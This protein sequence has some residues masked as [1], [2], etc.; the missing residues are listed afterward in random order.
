MNLS[1]RFITATFSLAFLAPFVGMT[2]AQGAELGSSDV[3]SNTFTEISYH[4]DYDDDYDYDYDKHDKH[5]DDDDDDD[6]DKV[7]R[8]YKVKFYESD[9]NDYDNNKR[10]YSVKRV[11]SH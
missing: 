5:D 3:I 9:K 10:C 6:D 1:I 2:N 8:T 7:S 11:N 4:K